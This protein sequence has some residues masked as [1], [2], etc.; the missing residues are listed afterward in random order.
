MN[1]QD[2]KQIKCTFIYDGDTKRKHRLLVE[3]AVGIVGSIYIP[4]SLNPIPD[5]I[6]IEK[7]KGESDSHAGC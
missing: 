3:S 1:E 6:I 5:T 7:R 4:K 2:K